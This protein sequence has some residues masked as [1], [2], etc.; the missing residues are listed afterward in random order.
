[1]QVLT[2]NALFAEIS[3]EES[4]VVSGGIFQGGLSLDQYIFGVGSA[5]LLFGCVSQASAQF[6]WQN[7]LYGRDPSLAPF[8]K[9][10]Q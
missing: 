4:S 10:N 9:Y 3:D 5:Y 6:A 7:S 1:M 2:N 8:G